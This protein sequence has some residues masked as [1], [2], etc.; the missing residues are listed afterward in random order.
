MFRGVAAAKAGDKNPN[1]DLLDNPDG[2]ILRFPDQF[3]CDVMVENFFK[4]GERFS[5]DY[6]RVAFIQSSRL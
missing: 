5:P 6:E 1:Q 3:I 4:P 2:K